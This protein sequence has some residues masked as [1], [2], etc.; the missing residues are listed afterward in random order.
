LTKHALHNALARL[1]V[2]GEGR[3]RLTPSQIQKAF[4]QHPGSL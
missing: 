3:V 1:S 2:Q 4:L